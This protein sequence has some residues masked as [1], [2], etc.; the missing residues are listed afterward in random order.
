MEERVVFNEERCKGCGLCV[1]ACP[2]GIVVL[3]K[4]TNSQGYP[5]ASVKEQSKCTSCGSCYRMCPDMVITVKK[6][7]LN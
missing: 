7:V 3:T 5:V 2:K 6:E 4:Q 1:N